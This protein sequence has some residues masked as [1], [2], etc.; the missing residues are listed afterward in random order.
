[1]EIKCF[2]EL[3]IVDLRLFPNFFKVVLRFIHSL[4]TLAIMSTQRGSILPRWFLLH[5]ALPQEGGALY[6]L[7]SLLFFIVN[8]LQ[9][10]FLFLVHVSPL[11]LI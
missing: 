8:L 2:I 6:G 3:V 1:M 11:D 7:L 4:A 9:E 10:L 5:I